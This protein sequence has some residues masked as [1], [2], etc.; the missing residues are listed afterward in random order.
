VTSLLARLAERALARE[1]HRGA[2]SAEPGIVVGSF[3][4]DNAADGHEEAERQGKV[5]ISF[6]YSDDM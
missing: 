5:L 6:S 4:T 3:G 2:S 1:H